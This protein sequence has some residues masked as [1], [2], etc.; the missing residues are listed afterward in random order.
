MQSAALRFALVT[1]AVIGLSAVVAGDPA[2][3][4][5]HVADTMHN[6][7]ATGPGEIRAVTETRVCI[8]CHTTHTSVADTP[9]WNRS[10]NNPGPFQQFPS[11]DGQG[12]DGTSALCLS[13][14]EGSLA[15]GEVKSS[16]RPIDVLGP[17]R[18]KRGVQQGALTGPG[19]HPVSIPMSPFKGGLEHGTTSGTRLK[20]TGRAQ[21]L[22]RLDARAKVQCTSCH[23][24]HSDRNYVPGEVPHFW[25]DG[26]V[27]ETCTHCHDAPLR[28]LG[29]QA[30]YLT[31][32][33]AS[34]HQMHGQQGGDLLTS[35]PD[36][37]CYQ[38]H[39]YAGDV[40]FLQE[41][42]HLMRMANPQPIAAEFDKPYRHP[43]RRMDS[44]SAHPIDSI[45]RYP[46]PG[47][48]GSSDPFGDRTFEAASVDTQTA[49]RESV[50]CQD[51]HPM[52]GDASST[53]ANGNR[54][55]P[56]RGERTGL[57]E[58]R[59]CFDCHGPASRS[60]AGDNIEELF[61][62]SAR[63]S[64]PLGRTTDFLGGV[65]VAGKGQI[66]TPIM[67]C[68][69]CHGSDDPTAPAGPHG[70][71]Y[72][73]LIIRPYRDADAFRAGQP[74]GALCYACHDE[75]T[76]QNTGVGWPG[77]E[78]HLTMGEA[79]CADCHNPHGSMSYPGLV[80]FD[81]FGGRIRPAKDGRLEYKPNEGMGT[82]TVN[83]HGTEHVDTGEPLSIKAIQPRLQPWR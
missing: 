18:L 54:A 19:S 17:D 22:G 25:R 73:G 3:G 65:G 9:L 67:G 1:A 48:F 58:A 39:G 72:Q 15:L 5:T 8:F 50:E 11:L 40:D 74:M 56:G 47:A 41:V 44:K 7:A 23:D 46:I 82:C 77:H 14:H 63:S 37:F 55:L 57:S 29:H 45:A 53:K 28:H 33:C 60:G 61:S 21:T 16:D 13:C 69:S 38:C 62:A 6:L 49:R 64:H 24:A 75:T 34:C 10:I 78:I 12:I 36:T 68:T 52:H 51:C 70:S 66:L 42:S 4:P 31:N 32:G 43:V 76:L 79:E 20:D 2:K 80:S 35:D 83:C 30:P 27:E 26:S 71:I 59:L 81:I